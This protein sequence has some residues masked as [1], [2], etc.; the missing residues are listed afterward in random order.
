MEPGLDTSAHRSAP[1][2]DLLAVGRL[3]V[4]DGFAR[5][6]A[7]GGTGGT[8]SDPARLPAGAGHRR[9]GRRSS[10]SVRSPAPAASTGR[11][12]HRPRAPRAYP[13][14]SPS[15]RLGSG[16][17]LVPRMRPH[18][19]L[20][21]APRPRR[22]LRDPQPWPSTATRLS[23]TPT[24]ASNPSSQRFRCGPGGSLMSCTCDYHDVNI[25]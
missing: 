3:R 2:L 19:P 12:P 4:S 5:G 18:S 1:P 17:L 10:G 21:I 11:E 25:R 7:C 8:A 9:A 6:P 24:H 13:P 22:H 14:S 23:L 15:L 16:S 20:G